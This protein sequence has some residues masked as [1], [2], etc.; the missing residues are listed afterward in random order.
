MCIQE[1]RGAE[2][3]KAGVKRKSFPGTPKAGQHVERFEEWTVLG[4]G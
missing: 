4:R 1:L 3:L 2:P